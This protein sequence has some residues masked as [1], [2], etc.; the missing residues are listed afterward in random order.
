MVDVLGEPIAKL[1]DTRHVICL[2]C[3]DKRIRVKEPSDLYKVNIDP[4]GQRC[5][6]CDSLINKSTWPAPWPVKP[7]TLFSQEGCKNCLCSLC[8]L[9]SPSDATVH[10]GCSDHEAEIWATQ[11][12][13]VDRTRDDM[14]SWS[15]GEQYGADLH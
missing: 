6:E 8:G 7:S 4:Y 5:H 15:R 10:P 12:G 13:E 3:N 2:K 14:E 9:Q 1:I 11:E